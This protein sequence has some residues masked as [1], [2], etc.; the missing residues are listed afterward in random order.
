MKVWGIG[1]NWGG[2]SMLSE[3]EKKKAVGIGWDEASAPALYA[4]M[5]EIDIGDIVY[6]K[7]YM[8]KGRRLRIKAVGEVIST[9]FEKPNVFGNDHRTVCVKWRDGSFLNIQEHELTK[10]EHRYNVY[11]HTLYREYNHTIVKKMLEY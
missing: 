7:S 8:L 1:A 10:E 6:V 3:F 5:N 2:K 4:M 11:S 9:A